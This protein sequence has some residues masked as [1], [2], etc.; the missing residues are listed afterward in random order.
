MAVLDR[1][2]KRVRTLAD[3]LD[4]ET[5]PPTLTSQLVQFRQQVAELQSRLDEAERLSREKDALI[6][7]LQG[8]AA[9]RD[10][11]IVDGAAYFI[12]KDG[13]A[14]DGPFCTA[15]F[16]RNHEAVRVIPAA[17]PKGGEGNQSE[18]VQ[19]SRCQVPFRSQRLGEYLNPPPSEPPAATPKKAR[20]VRKAPAKRS[21]SRST[22]AKNSKSR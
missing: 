14:L 21:A 19:C 5:E 15:C 18:W 1:V 16:E 3:T 7:Q 10:N 8:I 12:K 9:L 4:L 22:A 2:L 6:A 11:M 13:G 17:K 20:P